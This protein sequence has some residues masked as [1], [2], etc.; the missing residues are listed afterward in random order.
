MYGNVKDKTAFIKKGS[1]K[2]V[3]NQKTIEL[4]INLLQNLTLDTKIKQNQF[5]SKPSKERTLLYFPNSYFNVN[6]TRI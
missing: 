1:T 4:G 6:E 2:L 3:V 5:K